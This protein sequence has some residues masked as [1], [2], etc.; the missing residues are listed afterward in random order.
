M[1]LGELVTRRQRLLVHDAGIDEEHVETEAGAIGHM[2]KRGSGALHAAE[3]GHPIAERRVGEAEDLE[4]RTFLV[5]SIDWR[6]ALARESHG[7]SLNFCA[8]GMRRPTPNAF[9]VR[10]RPGAAWRRLYSLDC[11][12]ASTR[13]TIAAG[14]P[15]AM[16]V[17]RPA[18]SSTNRSS[19]RSSSS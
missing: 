17:S 1:R 11:T 10:I 13:S 15:S 8:I 19:T 18:P 16:M 12:K 3:D 2:A 9:L 5:M 6:E 7:H 14:I 4:R